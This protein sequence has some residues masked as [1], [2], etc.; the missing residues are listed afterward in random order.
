MTQAVHEIDVQ[1]AFRA[2]ARYRVI[3][4]REPHELMSGRVAQA[5]N[6]PLGR[7]LAEAEGWDRSQPLLMVCRSGGRS[8]RA[9]AELVRLGFREVANLTGGMLAWSAFHLPMVRP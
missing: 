5:E 7:L 1:E 9:A 2:L 8:G 6:V 3:D 4:V